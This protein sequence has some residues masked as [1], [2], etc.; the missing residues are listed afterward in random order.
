MIQYV[1]INYASNLTDIVN[2]LSCYFWTGTLRRYSK[3]NIG[4][5]VKICFKPGP[6]PLKTFNGSQV[7]FK[8]SVYERVGN[9][10][11][12]SYLELQCY[13]L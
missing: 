13:I 3:H 4:I 1:I 8:K 11:K 7:S 5:K 10:L 12:Y 9:F 2:I 6:H